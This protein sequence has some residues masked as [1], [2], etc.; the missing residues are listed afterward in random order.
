MEREAEDR[1]FNSHKGWWGLFH[2][3]LGKISNWSGRQCGLM[4]VLICQ[5]FRGF[6]VKALTEA[7]VF[8]HCTIGFFHLELNIII[9]LLHLYRNHGGCVLQSD[10]FKV[11]CRSNIIVKIESAHP[12]P[13]YNQS[14]ML[15]ISRCHPCRL[16]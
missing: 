11:N 9:E 15:L 7:L 13:M 6:S 2:R 16:V 8:I 14:L 5:T 3:G 10:L 1:I 12:H 4:I